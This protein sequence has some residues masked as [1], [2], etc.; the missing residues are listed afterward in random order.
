MSRQSSHQVVMVRISPR[1]KGYKANQAV[2]VEEITC[3]ALFRRAPL[4]SKNLGVFDWYEPAPDGSSRTICYQYVWATVDNCLYT[5]EV[6]GS[7]D[8][9]LEFVG[10][11]GGGGGYGGGG[12]CGSGRLSPATQCGRLD[13]LD[14]AITAVHLMNAKVGVFS[15]PGVRVL[16]VAT[17]VD[18]I[19]FRVERDEDARKLQLIPT[20]FFAS[21]DHVSMTKI[22]SSTTGRIFMS[23]SD[24]YLYELEY[25]RSTLW[26]NVNGNFNDVTCSKRRVVAKE[27]LLEL[28]PPFVSALFFV[29]RQ[30]IVDMCYDEEDDAVFLL[31]LDGATVRRIALDGGMVEQY[32]SALGGDSSSNRGGGGGGGRS[33]G[34]SESG[35]TSRRVPRALHVLDREH[36]FR[37]GSAS[38]IKLAVVMHDG[39]IVYITMDLGTKRL[40]VGTA[41]AKNRQ[42]A[43]VGAVMVAQA[44]NAKQT[45]IIATTKPA[46]GPLNRVQVVTALPRNTGAGS[47][48]DSVSSSHALTLNHTITEEALDDRPSSAIGKIYDI[49]C[50][51][52]HN[53]AVVERLYWHF[54]DSSQQQ[55]QQRKTK[56]SSGG[57]SSADDL[58]AGRGGANKA[59]DA[60]GWKTPVRHVLAHISYCS[61]GTDPMEYCL[62][63]LLRVGVP[64]FLVVGETRVLKVAVL[65]LLDERM[66]LQ[67][68]AD[69]NQFLSQM[70]GAS[71]THHS[72]K[73]DA[74]R[75]YICILLIMLCCT[76][77]DRHTQAST[78][79]H[80]RDL[81]THELFRR[82]DH[83]S[84]W[85]WAA[86]VHKQFERDSK[87]GEHGEHDQFLKAVQTFI[88]Q[89]LYRVASIPFRYFTDRGGD[90]FW[91]GGG[92]G[93]G[94]AA[95]H[96]A[97]A[98]AAAVAAAGGE[99]AAAALHH[100]PARVPESVVRDLVSILEK[101][102]ELLLHPEMF[103]LKHNPP[104]ADDY[105]F[106]EAYQD[107]LDLLQYLIQMLNFL[108]VANAAGR[109]VGGGGGGGG[110]DN[111]WDGKSAASSLE[112]EAEA[113]RLFQQKAG[114]FFDDC[115]LDLLH[116]K[117][118][119]LHHCNM[120]IMA[121]I[122]DLSRKERL[123]DVKLLQ[124]KLLRRWPPAQPFFPRPADWYYR[125]GGGG[126]GGRRGGGGGGGGGGGA[127]AAVQLASV[128]KESE[129]MLKKAASFTGYNFDQDGW[130]QH[131]DFSF[132][133]L[134][135]YCEK[136]YVLH[137]R[138]VASL[139]HNVLIILRCV[140]VPR[141]RM[142]RDSWW[143]R[144]LGTL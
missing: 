124:E 43:S 71:K 102:L 39:D 23:G 139:H 16:V 13:R 112:A 123:D 21:S 143:F 18:I 7:G 42:A 99:A 8:E 92:G 66:H 6:S 25:R 131:N 113:E 63:P 90:D 106:R 98:A 130:R 15:D 9:A 144:R 35:G 30:D 82:G 68:P 48:G 22:V 67:R 117:H 5:W 85:S 51:Q 75:N 32:C 94:S 125:G 104:Q 103:E 141:V 17:T 95:V 81:F 110:G 27:Y 77:Q 116:N 73:N 19:L 46:D 34:S 111:G 114:A 138:A 60:A 14:Q 24:G 72:T 79:D 134:R 31:M 133:S 1:E 47:I 26:D 33:G 74:A 29:G 41:P 78:W 37:R 62:D 126:G 64:E 100:R 44:F 118:D 49:A 108:G 12:G 20:D 105:S 4:V 76:P 55:Q 137:A 69:I 56:R 57:S 11:G 61:N 119:V 91:A 54:K 3:P 142:E 136:L 50:V 2:H 10:R 87:R 36:P 70:L 59:G 58:K 84:S 88:A 89:V 93:G 52:N 128:V 107:I 83:T 109:V 97:A 65:R 132:Q 40:R 80:L 140:C 129:F 120:A 127:A 28:L 121:T 101:L 86:D 45:T 115:I 96:A 122:A 38:Q 53:A 135:E